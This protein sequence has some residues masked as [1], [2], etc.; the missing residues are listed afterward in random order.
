MNPAAEVPVP[1]LA[2][3][4]VAWCGEE[5]REVRP[6]KGD[7]SDRRIF[8]LRSAR[9]T[10]IGI[11]GPNIPENRAFTGFARAFRLTPEDLAG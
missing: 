6:L 10:S 3:M 9:R 2:A 1:E 7:A 4:H 8:R 11:L 5:V